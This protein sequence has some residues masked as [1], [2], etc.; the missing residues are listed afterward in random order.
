MKA[1]VKWSI[2]TI[3]F[4]IIAGF[5]L[6]KIF[7][8]FFLGN[9]ENCGGALSGVTDDQSVIRNRVTERWDALM[10]LDM[11]KVYS[12]ATPAY[13]ETYDLIHLNNQYGAQIKRTGI[14]ILETNILVD[15]PNTADVRL[16]LYFVT[17]GAAAGSVYNGS[18]Y[19]RETWVKRNGCWWYVERR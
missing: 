4:L 19:E 7:P 1:S 18:S 10:N 15:D 6:L 16:N 3:L 5:G 12:F 11:E 8:S 2:A 14:E 13:R 9:S 17:E